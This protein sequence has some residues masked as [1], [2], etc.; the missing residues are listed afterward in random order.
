MFPFVNLKRDIRAR[1][2][3]TNKD[4]IFIKHVLFL[5]RARLHVYNIIVIFG[6]GFQTFPRAAERRRE[7]GADGCG[8][9]VGRREEGGGS[10]DL[11]DSQLWSHLNKHS[12]DFFFICLQK[13]FVCFTN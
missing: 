8:L 5:L 1:L 12:T 2:T 10:S 13:L 7:G 9:S 4:F 3:Q 11:L 6:R